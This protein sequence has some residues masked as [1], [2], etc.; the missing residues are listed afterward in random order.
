[1]GKAVS[2]FINFGSINIDHVY[3]VESFVKAG[4][5]IAIKEYQKFLGG[6]GLNQSVALA[7]AGATVHHV[8]RIHRSDEWLLDTIQ[9]LGVG[10]DFIGFSEKST[11]HAIIQIDREGENAICV[12]GGAN[13]TL[14]TQQ[15]ENVLTSS[16][17]NSV[18]MLQNETNGVEE[19][20]RLAD[21]K[22]YKVFFNP[23]PYDATVN[24]LPLEY[25]DVLVLNESEAQGLSGETQMEKIQKA[26]LA[27]NP[28]GKFIVTLG[29]KG[30][31]FFDKENRH[32]QKAY[33]VKTVDTTG[34]GDT[35]CGFFAALYYDGLG[36]AHA[37]EYAARAAA[38]CVGKKGALN[39]IPKIG[40][41]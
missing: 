10:S 4:E 19:I 9:R 38:L 7:S 11:G 39:T 31:C 6:K 41:L 25:V 3:S 17:V 22:G 34:A 37:M 40:D 26:F 33:S 2:S 5:T 30:A 12:Y 24:E 21:A 32:F 27:R 36:V 14:T 1:M 29:V 15:I 8:G 16:D 13:R 23:A 20:I 28:L 18:V 35:F